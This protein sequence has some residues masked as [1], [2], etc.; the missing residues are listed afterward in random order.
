MAKHRPILIIDDEPANLR[1]L[2]KTLKSAEHIN[3]KE[4]QDPR[5]AIETYI[6]FKPDI[7]LLDLNM[8]HLNGY[9][10]IEK[11]NALKD[12]MLPPIMVITAQDDRESVYK[13]L[14]L[15]A[16]DYITK[17]FDSRELL[18]RVENMLAVQ[19]AHRIKH[20]QNQVLEEALSTKR[21]ELQ[22][23]RIQIISRLARAAEFKD[24]DTGDHI[25]RMSSVSA[26]L[27]KALGF[28]DE[29]CD[30]ILNASPMHDVGKL[31]IPDK[32][33]LKPGKLD[34]DEWEVMKT[35]TTIGAELLS[36]DSSELLNTA[37]TIALMHHEKW[38]GSGYPQGLSENS[39]HPFA[40]IVAIAD[41]FDAL[42]SVRPYKKA[43][44]IQEAREYIDQN[45]GKHF[46]PEI[47]KVFCNN[48]DQIIKIYQKYSG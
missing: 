15:G 43:W 33:L 23:T 13:A 40:R 4:V 29:E 45:S 24:E 22:K 37:S 1:L 30:L 10:V 5:D 31:G 44:P 26:M 39:I 38:D 46:D 32:I 17:P 3:T 6:S 9:Q 8:P 12:P 11:L 7:I 21:Q 35:H 19:F 28:I 14:A 20:N 25:I 48:F 2:S 34:K 16:R 41:V 47:V 18:I 27:A 42:T 36:G